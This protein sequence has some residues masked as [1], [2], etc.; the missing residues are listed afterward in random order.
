MF[1]FTSHNVLTQ[2]ASPLGYLLLRCLRAYL[3]LTMWESLEVHTEDTIASGRQ[4]VSQLGKLIT[5]GC[6]LIAAELAPIISYEG[7]QDCTH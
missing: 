3:D 4:A 1:I 2:Q 7:V 5:V 6:L